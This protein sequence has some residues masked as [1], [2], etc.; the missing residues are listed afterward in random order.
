MLLLLK[1]C[2]KE[3]MHRQ[4]PQCRS[5]VAAAGAAVFEK[6]ARAG[7]RVVARCAAG[8]R[9][10]GALR[11]LT[12]LVGAEFRL[13]SPSSGELTHDYGYSS[14]AAAAATARCHSWSRKSA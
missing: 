4:W 8:C 9:G 5:Y 10:E 13:S 3:A 14:P 7:D 2:F 11:S 12:H 1:V 6:R